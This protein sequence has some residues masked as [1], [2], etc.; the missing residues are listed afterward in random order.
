MVTTTCDKSLIWFALQQS[1]GGIAKL[2]LTWSVVLN[3]PKQTECCRLT[4]Q[5][6]ELASALRYFKLEI[7]PSCLEVRQS[8]VAMHD[9]QVQ[10][11]LKAV[12]CWHHLQC[13][14]HCSHDTAT[15]P[16]HVC[17]MFMVVPAM[18]HHRTG[19]SCMSLQS[20]CDNKNNNCK[21]CCMLGPTW[22][23]I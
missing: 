8:G 19:D 21:C 17:P 7:C 10:L 12:L 4:Y 16:Q 11:R 22:S 23:A 20:Y 9:G 13:H 6:L 18:K 14:S 3:G 2:S 5:I 1:N 15:V